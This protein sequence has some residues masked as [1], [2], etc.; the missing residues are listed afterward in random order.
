MM[1]RVAAAVKKEFLQ[2][3]RD[4]MLI[5]LILWTYTIEVVLCAY[6]LTFDV[7]NLRLAVYDQD[8]S[9]LSRSLVERFTASEFFSHATFVSGPGEIDGLLD[10]GKADMGMIIPP[11]FSDQVGEGRGADV[12]IVLGG[13]NSNTA[14][15]A[16]G[17][18]ITILNGFSR[19]DFTAYLARK[20]RLFSLPAVEPRT[21]IWY[22][23]ALEFRYF[24]VISMIVVA[25]LLVGIVHAAASMVREKETGTMEQLVVTPLRK[26]E[27]IFAKI[28]PTFAIGMA[29]LF[30]SLLIA[31]WF[32]L[33]MK[34]SIPLFFVASA[35]SL[36][37][38]MGI[39]VFISTLSRNLQQALLLSFFF[40]FPVMF[41]SGTLVPIE[42]M[43]LAMQYLSYLSPIRYY[44]E[45][46]LGIFLKGTGLGILWPQFLAMFLF[47]LVIFPLSLL[48]LRKH[49]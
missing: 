3:S 48:R 43:P 14:N 46:A 2:F 22:N 12:Q 19:E 34:G 38:S 24:I 13:T 32:R 30:P 33:P 11:D 45:I 29:S 31:L 18:A 15:I 41:L 27:I 28:A 40:I 35:V 25:S 8:G 39:G 4:R 20:G 16:R 42:S 36:F 49:L 5:I 37:A 10:A 26:H 7:K 17:Y 9:Q 23:P 1:Q 44:M 47:G 21:R 6:A